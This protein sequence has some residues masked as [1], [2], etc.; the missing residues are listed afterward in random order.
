MTSSS[1]RAARAKPP[2]IRLKPRLINKPLS[3]VSAS[4]FTESL[5]SSSQASVAPSPPLTPAQ[6]PLPVSRSP[7][8][9][10]ALAHIGIIAPTPRGYDSPKR[11]FDESS[12]SS[13]EPEAALA[14]R[15]RHSP[16]DGDDTPAL[17]RSPGSSADSSPMSSPPST[18][19]PPRPSAPLPNVSGNA[20]VSRGSVLLSHPDR[21]GALARSSSLVDATRRQQRTR[22][23]HLLPCLSMLLV[24]GRQTG[25]VEWM[26]AVS[27][28]SRFEQSQWHL[29]SATN[30]PNAFERT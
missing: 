12:C 2:S 11:T 23:P 16:D 13:E 21:A 19:P 3:I 14:K 20:S 15:T 4:S 1:P 8:P 22:Q 28:S 6:V 25:Q 5:P 9:A 10:P 30:I 29:P 7:S 26:S 18:P 24:S 27:A 17:S